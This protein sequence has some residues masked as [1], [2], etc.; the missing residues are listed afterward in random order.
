MQSPNKDS[1]F[2]RIGIVA[3]FP[4]PNGGMSLQAEK[5]WEGLAAEGIAVELIATNPSPPEPLWF[6]RSVPGLRTMV[7]E[8]QYLW[9]L[10]RKRRTLG[11][12]HHLAASGPYF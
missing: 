6:V 11:I 12:I 9:T 8:T 1:Q 10:L 2:P 3:P 4:P 7:R 5:L